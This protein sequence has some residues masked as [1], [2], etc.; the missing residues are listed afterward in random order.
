MKLKF[1]RFAEY[2][3]LALGT[4]R[5][6]LGAVAAIACWLL[7]GPLFQ[8]SEQWQLV[9]NSF[10]TI[11]TF[12]MVFVIQNTQNRDFQ[13]LQL[14]L[15]A[16]LLASDGPARSLASLHNISDDDLHRLEGALTK[17]RGRHNI[18]EIVRFLEKEA[19]ADELK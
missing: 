6:F 11:A 10:T 8:Y 19:T 13:A 5:A 16:L 12:L 1:R 2:V 3:S 4:P 17:A 15:D 9:V 14:K 18:D 7:T